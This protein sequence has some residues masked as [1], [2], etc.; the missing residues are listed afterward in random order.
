MAD[1]TY[2]LAANGV[3]GQSNGRYVDTLVAFV[4]DFE[5]QDLTEYSGDTGSFSFTSDTSKVTEGTYALNDTGSTSHL[6]T[7]S[8]GLDNYP[9]RGDKWRADVYIGNGGNERLQLI[10]HRQDS[11]NYYWAF[12][13]ADDGTLKLRKTESGS[14]SD[15]ASTTFSYSGSTI[16]QVEVDTTDTAGHDIVLTLYD[17]GGSQLTSITGNDSTLDSGGIG[18][19]HNASATPAE[20]ALDNWRI[21]NP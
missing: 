4:D 21:L 14:S 9:S 2:D 13:E 12:L 16:Y 1:I 3:Y 8:S 17:E 15:L 19:N 7:S 11:N 20:S 18:Y 5:D 10:F 6:I